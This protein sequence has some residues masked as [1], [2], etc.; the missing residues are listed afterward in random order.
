MANFGDIPSNLTIGASKA[1]RRNSA[2]NAFENFTPLANQISGN[3]SGATA[4]LSEGTVVFAGGNNITLS[5]N[6]N[7]ITI[8][9]PNAIAQTNQ[10]LG[11]Y[12]TGNT[13]QSSSGTFDARSMTFNGL[14]DMSVG[15]SN[16]SIQLSSPVQTVE[17]QS[18]GMS[19]LG[20]TS[21]TTGVASGGQV[22][23]V[24]VGGNNITLSQSLNGASGTITISNNG[25]TSQSNQA[26]SAGNGSFTFQTATFADSNGISFSTGTQGIFASHNGL[27][28]QSN[29]ALSGSNGSFTFQTATFGNANG[30]SFLTNNGSLVGSYTVPTVT[31]SS[32]TVSNSATSAIVGRLAFSDSN[33]IIFGLSTSNN[34][35]HTITASHNGLTSQSNQVASASNGS[36]AFQT[37]GFS[38]ANNVTFGTSA[39]SIVTASVAA[40]TVQTQN[41]HNVTLSGNTAGVMAQISSGTMTLAGGNNITVSQNGNAVTIVGASTAA[42]SVVPGI[43]SIQVSNTTYTTGNVIFS[44]ANGLSFGSSAGGAVTASY[45][46]PTVTNSSWTVSNTA[47]SATVGRLM[48]NDSNGLTFGL[49]TSNNGNHTITASHNGLTS[50]SGQALS[51]ANGSFAFQTASFSNLNGISFG[52]S[53]GSAITASH[54]GITSQTNQTIGAYAVSNTTQSTSGTIDA[55]SLSFNG[56]G[57][58]SVGVSN[59]LVVI[60]GGAGAAVSINISA[61]TTSN[62]LTN[63]ILSDSNNVS[64]GLNGS[65]ITATVF[66][67]TYSF[68]NVPEYIGDRRGLS[69]T[70][71]TPNVAYVGYAPFRENVSAS[72]FKM[73]VFLTASTSATNSGQV[74]YTAGIAFY[75]RNATNSTVLTQIY[76]TSYTL[77]GSYSS[78]V[79]MALGWISGVG[80]STSY[81][82]NSSSS[83]GT[84][85][86]S[87]VNGQREFIMPVNVSFSKGEY[88]FAFSNSSSGAGTPGNLLRMSFIPA[89]VASENQ[90]GLGLVGATAPGL[91]RDIGFFSNPNTFLNGYTIST[92]QQHQAAPAGYLINFTA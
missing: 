54:N 40:Q 72:L 67:S 47:T 19:N 18:I 22:R 75:S 85:I 32:W 51:A 7:S 21:G 70:S 52:T 88:W 79:S 12:G 41:V 59:G 33:G 3:T 11:F 49:S 77:S 35:N 68:K 89:I 38:N 13:T 31:N 26:V 55:R 84:N 87:L 42:Q 71:W 57:G 60:S 92:Q 56:A 58:V 30:M 25:L 61:G 50:Q 39:G 29:Q 23:F 45:T 81:Q 91:L 16:G 2:D 1:V 14:G 76:S 34:G 43:Q 69:I 44:N 78:N 63:F 74:G 48:F 6:M 46:V 5:Q 20:N 53:V 62:N 64:F 28:S 80:N 36:F 17:S 8:S 86:A 73:P 4:M 66:D 65:T 15:F 10:T 24:L 82:T 83:A 9:A 37:L 90:M 27:T